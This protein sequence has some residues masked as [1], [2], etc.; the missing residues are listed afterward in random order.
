MN[1]IQS[2]DD[3]MGGTMED[4]IISCNSFNTDTFTATLLTATTG[5]I[6]TGNI[7]NINSYNIGTDSIASNTGTIITLNSTTGNIQTTNSDTITNSGAITTSYLNIKNGG[8]VYIGDSSTYS[9]Q[10]INT[11]T[12]IYRYILY[13]PINRSI[14]TINGNNILDMDD[15]KIT[16]PKIISPTGNITTLTSTT[17][18]SNIGNITTVNSTDVNTQSVTAVDSN[19]SFSTILRTLS[20]PTSPNVTSWVEQSTPDYFIELNNLSNVKYNINGNDALVIQENTT[21]FKNNIVCLAGTIPTLTSTTGNITTGNI[22]NLNTNSIQPQTISNV[23]NICTTSTNDINIGG[24]GKVYFNKS[25]FNGLEFGLDTTGSLAPY[26][27]FHSS[28]NNNN[29]DASIYCDGGTTTNAEGNLTLKAKNINLNGNISFSSFLKTQVSS[30]KTLNNT[31]QNTN[32]TPKFVSVSA[33]ATVPA[34]WFYAKTDTNTTPTTIVAQSTLYNSVAH[35]MFFIVLP[36]Y[37][38]RV[39]STTGTLLNWTEWG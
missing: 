11:D 38:Y 39:E 4:G 17:I 34:T 27:D 30:V 5:N 7:N 15:T 9:E 33:F 35:S 3:G 1:S 32:T 2:F 13:P 25:G 10:F 24:S 18:N 29:Y 31:Y 36:N 26:I 22:T 28:G 23:V 21:T 6:T 14:W 16:V 8:F 12:N 37:Y 19:V 20:S